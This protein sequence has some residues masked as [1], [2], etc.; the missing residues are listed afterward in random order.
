M[1][2]IL[3][4]G[5]HSGVGKTTVAMALMAA[6]AR[7][8]TVAPFKVGPDY[9]DPSHH[10]AICGRPSRNLDTFMMGEEGVRE[11]FDRAV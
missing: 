5:T 7:R 8:Y 11:T 9:I 3:I 6:F 2:A 10:T 4:A 1:P